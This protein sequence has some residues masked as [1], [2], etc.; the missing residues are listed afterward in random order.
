M[1]STKDFI[2]DLGGPA[3]V[4]KLLDAT[5]QA[6]C[7]WQSREEIPPEYWFEFRKILGRNPPRKLFGFK[8]NGK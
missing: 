8:G 3:I 6:I 7:N 2:R 4:A 5:P 1:R